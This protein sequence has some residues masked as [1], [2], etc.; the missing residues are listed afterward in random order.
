M[1]ASPTQIRWL[2]LTEKQRASITLQVESTRADI[3]QRKWSVTTE[4][5]YTMWVRRYGV[6]LALSQ[7]AR[8]APDATASVEALAV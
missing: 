6:W 2:R 5:S 4:R 8:T 1:K 3:R 7:S